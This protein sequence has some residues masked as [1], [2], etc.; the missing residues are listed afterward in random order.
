MPAIKYS[1]DKHRKKLWRPYK[2]NLV[3]FFHMMWSA[4]GWKL[5]ENEEVG[6][7]GDPKLVENLLSGETKMD[8]EREAAIS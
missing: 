1:S 5:N 6:E 8:T 4:L 2:L 7:G 3:L